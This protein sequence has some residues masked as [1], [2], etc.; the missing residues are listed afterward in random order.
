MKATHKLIDDI[1]VIFLSGKLDLT[2]AEELNEVCINNFKGNKIIFSFE[3]LSFVGSTGITVFLDMVR[4]LRKLIDHPI[5]FTHLSS[6]YQK[7]FSANILEHYESFRSVQEAVISF[8]P[9]N[10]VLNTE[11]HIQ[12]NGILPPT[13][14][15]QSIPGGATAS[16]SIGVQSMNY[17]V[18]SAPDDLEDEVDAGRNDSLR[19]D[20]DRDN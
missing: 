19:V 2:G 4:V 20:L 13:F 6:E 14:S 7:I 5:K 15:V 18:H 3:Q 10:Q 11:P 17:E 8:N 9:P 1:D 12:S 16:P